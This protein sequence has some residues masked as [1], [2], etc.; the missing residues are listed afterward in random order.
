MF[1]RQKLYCC[2]FTSCIVDETNSDEYLEEL[3]KNEISMSELHPFVRIDSFTIENILIP[4]VPTPSRILWEIE[5]TLN[6]KSTR[7]N[8]E[9]NEPSVLSDSA[10]EFCVVVLSR[11]LCQVL[12]WEKTSFYEPIDEYSIIRTQIPNLITFLDKLDDL[13]GD[14]PQK[15]STFITFN[16]V[17][18]TLLLPSSTIITFEIDIQYNNGRYNNMEKHVF[19]PSISCIFSYHFFSFGVF[20]VADFNF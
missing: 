15:I 10:S 2:V 3:F 18:D 13:N 19:S 12:T 6:K 17:S 7:D 5:I 1:K 20:R 14:N 11:L 4:H 8:P 16:P 9:K